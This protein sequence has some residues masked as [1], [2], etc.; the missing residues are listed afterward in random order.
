VSYRLLILFDIFTNVQ[1]FQIQIFGFTHNFLVLLVVAFIDSRIYVLKSWDQEVLD[2]SLSCLLIGDRGYGGRI[3]SFD[4]YLKLP[5]SDVVNM[6][7]IV[8]Q[9]RIP[10]WG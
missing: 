9:Y 6:E 1:Q 5:E 2:Y 10:C 8:Q 3:T 4:S 7:N